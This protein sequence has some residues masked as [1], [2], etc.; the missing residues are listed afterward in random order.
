[1]ALD[2][3][4]RI[5][6]DEARYEEALSLKRQSLRILTELGDVPHTLD[7]LSRVAN[8]QARLGRGALAAELLPASLTLHEE[9]GLPVA[10]SRRRR[11]C[12]GRRPP[13][14]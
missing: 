9:V 4:A 1:M 6:R 7:S 3:V 11:D 5:A 12:S 10:R 13:P 8:T 2:S 14:A